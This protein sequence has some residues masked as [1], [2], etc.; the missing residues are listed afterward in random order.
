MT[1][2]SDLEKFRRRERRHTTPTRNSSRGKSLVEALRDGDDPRN[3]R[4]SRRQN[5]TDRFLESAARR[6]GIVST[7]LPRRREIADEFSRNSRPEIGSDP[8]FGDSRGGFELQTPAIDAIKGGAA[9]KGAQGFFG[10]IDLAKSVMGEASAVAAQEREIRDAIAAAQI[11]VPGLDQYMAPFD[12]AETAANASAE[13]GRGVIGG[14]YDELEG[15]LAQNQAE[16]AAD[17]AAI[18][19]RQARERRLMEQETARNS[20]PSGLARELGVAGDLEGEQG[21]LDA[22][23]SQGNQSADSLTQRMEQS[24]AQDFNSRVE[25]VGASEAAALANTQANLQ[26]LLGQIGLGRADAQRQ[27]TSDAAGIQRQNADAARTIRQEFQDQQQQEQQDQDDWRNEQAGLLKGAEEDPWDGEAFDR[28]VE[29]NPK[30]TSFFMSM[31]DD[32]GGKRNR[33]TAAKAKGELDNYLQQYREEAVKAKVTPTNFN[34][35]VL[36]DWIDDYFSDRRIINEKQ[37]FQSGGD[38]QFLAE[39]YG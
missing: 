38:P 3:P 19:D 26:A 18:A 24:Q 32:L 5:D 28:R 34:R 25:G 2:V 35:K 1:M 15:D 22:L 12:Q 13:A 8:T 4:G 9:R 16:F 6:A 21:L 30:A 17:Q 33:R 20:N 14:A 29:A 27:H 37:F 11:A 36:L 23:S 10:A 7:P 39:V 31:I